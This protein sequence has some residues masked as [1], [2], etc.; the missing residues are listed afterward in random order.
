MIGWMRARQV[1]LACQRHKLLPPFEKSTCPIRSRQRYGCA[2]FWQCSSADV[3]KTIHQQWRCDPLGKC[4]PCIHTREQWLEVA[5]FS[6]PL[7]YSGATFSKPDSGESESPD[8][9]MRC[10]YEPDTDTRSEIPGIKLCAVLQ[11]IIGP[12]I[13]LLSATG[14]CSPPEQPTR[15]GAPR[16]QSYCPTALNRQRSGYL[17]AGFHYQKKLKDYDSCVVHNRTGM[18]RSSLKSWSW[19]GLMGY[20]TLLCTWQAWPFPP[21]IASDLKYLESVGSYL[22]VIVNKRYGVKLELSWDRRGRCSHEIPNTQPMGRS[23]PYSTVQRLCG[24][25]ADS[26]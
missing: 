22:M 5:V 6:K 17:S 13:L 2:H 23:M 14:Y 11:K 20:V 16:S 1:R 7:S 26:A 15:F 18:F 21:M 4:C 8:Q 12:V 24:P 9:Y 19:S 10:R 3:R 25:V